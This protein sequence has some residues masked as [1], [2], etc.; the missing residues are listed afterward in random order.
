MLL[1][2]AAVCLCVQAAD[3]KKP[4]DIQVVDIKAVREN[5]QV[6]LDGRV[7]IT[8]LKRIQHLMLTFEFR[9]AGKGVVSSKNVLAEENVLEPGD[10]TAFSAQSECPPKAFEYKIRAFTGGRVELDVANPGPYPIQD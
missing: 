8:G 7:R 6:L 9:A 3:K 1:A 5:D 10:E 2:L 4:P